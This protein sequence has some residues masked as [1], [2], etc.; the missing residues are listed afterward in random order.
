MDTSSLKSLDETFRAITASNSI[1]AD[2]VATLLDKFAELMATAPTLTEVQGSFYTK[3]Q[4]DAMLQSYGKT[5]SIAASYVT[6]NMLTSALASYLKTVSAESLYYNRNQI[7]SLLSNYTKTAETTALANRVSK[8]ETSSTSSSSSSSSGAGGLIPIK[9][10]VVG[11]QLYLRGDIATL[12]K[13]YHPV[14]FRNSRKVNYTGTS[15]AEKK[16]LKVKKGWNRMGNIYTINVATDG[17]V[18]I[19]Q[20]SFNDL[21]KVES[22]DNSYSLSA[23]DFVTSSIHKDGKQYVSWA[24]AAFRVAT[25]CGYVQVR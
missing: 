12:L 25:E 1:S 19:I 10:E 18:S 7:I 20:N 21:N 2:T 14:L 8:L 9:A 3:A 4:I 5:S 11:G 17:L 16:H 24:N 6:Q 15:G 22:A 23:E 13:S